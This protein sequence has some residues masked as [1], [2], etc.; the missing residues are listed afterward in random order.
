MNPKMLCKLTGGL[1]AE[2]CDRLTEIRA[3]D[4][5]RFENESEVQWELLAL[6]WDLIQMEVGQ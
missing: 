2:A 1:H 3:G 4:A 6:A 5:E